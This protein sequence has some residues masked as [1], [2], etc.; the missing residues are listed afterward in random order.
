MRIQ[1]DVGAAG[2][3]GSG[4]AERVHVFVRH[5]RAILVMRGGTVVILEQF[6]ARRA[7]ARHAERPQDGIGDKLWRR[8][9]GGACGALLP[10]ENA[11]V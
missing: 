5:D 1:R 4:A 9:G 7:A 2:D 11:I 3:Q 8:H 6:G 10:E